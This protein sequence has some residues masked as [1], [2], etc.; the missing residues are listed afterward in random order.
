MPLIASGGAGAAEHFPPAV[1]AGADA[2]LAA[3][4]FHFGVLRIGDVKDALAARRRPG[5]LSGRPIADTCTTLRSGR[6]S[7]GRRRGGRR[8]RAAAPSARPRPC[9]RPRRSASRRRRRRCA[10]APDP[11]ARAARR[12]KSAAAVQSASWS[13]A[14]QRARR[15]AGL[16]PAHVLVVDGELGRVERRRPG[17]ARPSATTPAARRAAGRPPRRRASTS[18]SWSSSRCV[19]AASG[20]PR[21]SRLRAAAR[22]CASG[23]RSRT[24]RCAARCAVVQP[25]QQVGAS[26]PSSAS[27]SASSRRSRSTNDGEEVVIAEG[28]RGGAPRPVRERLA[29]LTIA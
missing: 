6:R 5:P 25:A 3:S 28:Y 11:A 19:Q 18:R 26:G 17:P 4:V 15:P 16:G 23:R 7:P 10:A 14:R 27:R 9:G 21:P 13:A 8:P 12:A 20:P 24:T 2:V 1:E 22:P 29:A